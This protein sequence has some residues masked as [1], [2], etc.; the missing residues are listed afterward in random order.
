MKVALHND[1]EETR[2]IGNRERIAQ[3]VVLPYLSLEFEEVLELEETAR[4][5]GGFGHTGMK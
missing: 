1:S 3:L 5:E 4:G 2:I